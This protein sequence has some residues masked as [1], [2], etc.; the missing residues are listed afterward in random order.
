MRPRLIRKV[1]AL[2][3]KGPRTTD[4]KTLPVEVESISEELGIRP[5]ADRAEQLRLLSAQELEELKRP[6]APKAARG[7]EVPFPEIASARRP[8]RP[9]DGAVQD[10]LPGF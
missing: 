5:Y 8:H 9:E 7:K 1:V 10:E 6:S 4:K 3:T 2:H